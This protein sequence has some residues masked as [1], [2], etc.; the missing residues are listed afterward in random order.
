MY[1]TMP[2]DA[3]TTGTVA[4][5]VGGMC[6]RTCQMRCS[7]NVSVCAGSYVSKNKGEERAQL[8]GYCYIEYRKFLGYRDHVQRSR[9]TLG[10]GTYLFDLQTAARC[11]DCFARN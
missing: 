5:R 10:G 1:I 9:V 2:L 8:F 3:A 4:G 7:S 6:S 11:R